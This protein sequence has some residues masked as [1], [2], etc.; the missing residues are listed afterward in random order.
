MAGKRRRP[1]KSS[2]KSTTLVGGANAS[3]VR[4]EWNDAKELLLL[5]KMLEVIHIGEISEEQWE[6]AA[7]LM[8]GED[9]GFTGS[10]LRY[11]FDSYSEE[12]NANDMFSQR[13][14]ESLKNGEIIDGKFYS[15]EAA[16][17]LKVKQGTMTKAERMLLS[18][19][20]GNGLHGCKNKDMGVTIREMF[21]RGKKAMEDEYMA[22]AMKEVQEEEADEAKREERRAQGLPSESEVESEDSEE[23]QG[24][25]YGGAK[26]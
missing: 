15:F 25:E 18:K 11:A 22:E 4:I 19:M 16:N 3:K 13:Y 12:N 8:G 20:V 14:N 9:E 17:D 26:A 1:T 7:T 21:E 6:L 5:T 23:S 24:E 2:G 10:V